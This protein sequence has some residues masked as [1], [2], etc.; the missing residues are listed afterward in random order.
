M[1]KRILIADDEKSV[2]KILRDRCLH[3]GYEVETAADGEEA[4]KK[5]KR[6]R[7]HLL[8]LDLKMPTMSGMHVLEESRRLKLNVRIL[9]LTALQSETLVSTC[10]ARGAHGYIVKPFNLQHIKESVESIL[11]SGVQRA[12]HE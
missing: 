10:L 8:F 12:A 3:W 4:L 9:I 2:V 11:S 5:L 7:P 1:K 6:F